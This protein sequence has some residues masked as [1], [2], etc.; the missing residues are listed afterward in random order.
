MLYPTQQVLLFITS[1]GAL[2]FATFDLFFGGVQ[3]N[4]IAV[5]Y[6]SVTGVV[7]DH[8]AMRFHV[9]LTTHKWH[10]ALSRGVGL[11]VYK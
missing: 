8:S 5:Q 11:T 2:R 3:H 4:L 10:P 9:T 6:Y 7:P 1:L